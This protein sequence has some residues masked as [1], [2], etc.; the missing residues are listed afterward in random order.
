MRAYAQA[1]LELIHHSGSQWNE[2]RLISPRDALPGDLIMFG[3]PIF[4]VAIYLGAGWTVNA[5][6]TGHYV[7]VQPVWSKVAG[8]VR[9]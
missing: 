7:D 9:P 5:P 8:V 6:F 1:G 2:G 4:H 3:D